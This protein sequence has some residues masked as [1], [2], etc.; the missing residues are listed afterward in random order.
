ML[1]RSMNVRHGL[2]EYLRLLSK[3]TFNVYFQQLAQAPKRKWHGE[4]ANM[5]Y[6][7]YN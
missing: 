3:F 6:V 7:Y 4:L 2:A 1:L 5:S